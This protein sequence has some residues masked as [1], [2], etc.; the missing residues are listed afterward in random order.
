ML[1][2][3][4]TTVVQQQ[5]IQAVR[6][7]LRECVNKDLEIVG[8]Q[9]RQF[10]KEALTTARGHRAIHVEPLEDV[11]DGAY[12]LYATRSQPAAT[13]GEEAKAALILAEDPYWSGIGRWNSGLELRTA[14]SLEGRE[15]FRVFLCGLV[16]AL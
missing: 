13:D 12:R 16:E 11:L 1:G 14:L 8:I 10:Q 4:D 5:D 2:G 15:C 9:V 6:I 7:R 3:M